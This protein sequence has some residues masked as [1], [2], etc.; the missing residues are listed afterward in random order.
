MSVRDPHIHVELTFQARAATRNLL[1]S[2]FGL[3]ADLPATVT[4]GCGIVVAYAMT[5]AEPA[6]VTCLACRE[7]THREH[8]RLADQVDR[9]GR[10][11]GTTLDSDQVARAVDRHRAIVRQFAGHKGNADPS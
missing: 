5:S 3:A 2:T 1:A 11:P 4:T 6:S 7:H 9:L 10:L 8:L